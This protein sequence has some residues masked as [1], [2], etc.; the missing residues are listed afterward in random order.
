MFSASTHFTI[1]CTDFCRPEIFFKELSNKI[2]YK[3]I[4]LKFGL[5][6]MYAYW[7]WFDSFFRMWMLIVL[8]SVI[9]HI[10]S[11]PMGFDFGTDYC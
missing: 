5:V 11:W 10:N 9:F 4:F 2:L 6:G 7:E 1:Y 8:A 3:I